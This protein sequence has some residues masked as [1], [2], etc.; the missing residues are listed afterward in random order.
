MNHNINIFQTE[1]K[2]TRVYSNILRPLV[3]NSRMSS[4]RWI[5][6]IAEV[7]DNLT[8]QATRIIR[9]APKQIDSFQIISPSESEMKVIVPLSNESF[10]LR[11]KYR[12]AS[13]RVRV[14]RILEDLD[15]IAGIA[16]YKHNIQ[17]ERA[18]KD[19]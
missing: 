16:S 13:G 14:G 15:T 10:P 11:L 8:I 2:M 4:R 1:S 17:M 19:H 18:K 3:S 12:T 7:R 9:P 6:S 5:M